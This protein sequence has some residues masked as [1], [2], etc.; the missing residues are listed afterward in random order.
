MPRPHGEDE[1]AFKALWERL[2]LSVDWSL[3]YSTISEHSR[4]IAQLS[5]LDLLRK[6]HVYSVEAPTMWDVDFRTAVAQAE[7]EDR[8]QRGSLPPTAVRRRG[9]ADSFVIATTRPE[10]LPACVGVAA[11]PVRR[12]LPGPAGPRAR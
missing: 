11:H 1:K 12:A 7:V 2:G 5:F 3:E 6:G 4:R 8:P 10:L 9:G